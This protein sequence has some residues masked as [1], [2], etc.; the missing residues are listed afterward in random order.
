MKSPEQVLFEIQ[1]LDNDF[2]IYPQ[3]V[4]GYGDE[5]DYEQ[6]DG[7]KNGWNAAVMEYGRKISAIVDEA[8]EPWAAAEQ[9]FAHDAGRHFIQIDG[10][11][12][13][14]K[15]IISPTEIILD[16]PHSS[17]T[18]G[19][20]V[21]KEGNTDVWN[22]RFLKKYATAKIKMQWG[23]NLKKFEGIQMPGGV[24]L[25]GQKIYDE[26][27]DEIKELEEDLISTNVLPG[28]MFM[29]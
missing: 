18:S 29:G 20:T 10:T 21:T 4:K 24:T 23:S 17:N 15:K 3:A 6:R 11:A 25:N 26:A 22:D 27:I 5:R 14:I 19:I 2:G 12:K 9:V 7:F 13:Q 8:G 1:N 16:G 28:D